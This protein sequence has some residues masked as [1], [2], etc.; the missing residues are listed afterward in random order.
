MKLTAKELF[1]K[2]T[3]EKLEQYTRAITFNL[4]GVSVKMNTTDTVG[5]TLQAWLKQY[6]INNNIYFFEP[7]NTQEFPDFYLNDKDTTKHM[8]E[9]KAFNYERTPAFD[10]ANFESYCA[11]IKEKPYYLNADYI[12]FGYLMSEPGDITIK[13]IWLHKIW[14][15]AGTSTNFPLKTQV[16]RNM[17]YNI[18]PNS[19]FKIGKPSP[20]NNADDFLKAIY[21][22]LIKY[23][24]LSFANDWKSTLFIN[25]AYY[26][27]NKLIF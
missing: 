14:E 4:A 3:D 24:G 26:F 13:K 8:L 20:F 25:Y 18:R 12:I 21:Q 1:K 27:G 23:K 6:L 2:L 15:I 16:K 9:V 5:I 17:I 7:Y 19:S 22:T 11:S 10:I